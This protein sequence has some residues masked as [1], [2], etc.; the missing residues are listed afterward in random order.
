VHT[1]TAEAKRTLFPKKLRHEPLTDFFGG[2]TT[3]YNV[4]LRL[5]DHAQPPPIPFRWDVVHVTAP[6]TEGTA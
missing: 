6:A 5:N 4:K 2:T 1:D 3:K